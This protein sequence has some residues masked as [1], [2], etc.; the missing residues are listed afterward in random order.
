[1]QTAYHDDPEYL[2]GLARIRKRIGAVR[3][4]RH[5]YSPTAGELGAPVISLLLATALI[6]LLLAVLTARMGWR[7]AP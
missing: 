5:P 4:T 7:L 3:A 6:G 2:A 1:M